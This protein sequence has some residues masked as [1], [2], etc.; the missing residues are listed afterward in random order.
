M[1]ITKVHNSRTDQKVKREKKVRLHLHSNCI[2]Y[3]RLCDPFHDSE[4]CPNWKYNPRLGKVRKRN[5][6]NS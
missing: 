5:E 1:Y 2:H 4:N 3:A 6:K